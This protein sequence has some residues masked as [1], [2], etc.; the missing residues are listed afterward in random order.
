M[1]I[2]T[3]LEPV[4]VR[5]VV[6]FFSGRPDAGKILQHTV[7]EIRKSC[8]CEEAAV[9]DLDGYR[10]SE[11]YR[12]MM[13]VRH[14]RVVRVECPTY[15]F[16]L[17]RPPEGEPFLLGEG[18]EPSL[19]RQDFGHNLIRYLSE[20][21]NCSD[22]LLPG[23]FYDHVFHDEAILSGM[24]YDASGLNRLHDLR[25][26]PMDYDGPATIHTDVLREAEC[27]GIPCIGLWTHFP[28]YINGPH[29]LLMTRL[30]EGIGEFLETRF[31]T[32]A[33]MDRWGDRVVE[34][35]AVLEN[36]SELRDMVEGFQGGP[37]TETV[38]KVL[39]LG[40]FLKKRRTRSLEDEE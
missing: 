33:I 23:S 11:G 27:R 35:E 36:D 10:N 32:T 8:R 14:G 34:I 28:F 29:E 20:T 18:P 3:L 13:S 22:I 9:W 30:L 7:A 25:C 16:S 19:R 21:W 24:A 12:P 5:R 40:D 1:Q 31:D 26:R 6:L 17:C 37:R 2:Q 38:S 39:N 15:R 4:A